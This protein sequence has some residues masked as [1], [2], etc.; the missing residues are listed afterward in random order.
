M[1]QRAIQ[2][3]LWEQMLELASNLLK[4]ARKMNALKEESHYEMA[5]FKSTEKQYKSVVSSIES[6]TMDYTEDEKNKKVKP[7]INFLNKKLK[8][9]RKGAMPYIKKDLEMREL[10]K[11]IEMNKQYLKSFEK[12]F[13][14]IKLKKEEQ[15]SY[16]KEKLQER[17]AKL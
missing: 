13:K 17:L 4:R 2:L 1:K 11:N 12:V 5:K 3:D 8:E 6:L 10:S 9:V 16:D 15:G 7:F 14:D